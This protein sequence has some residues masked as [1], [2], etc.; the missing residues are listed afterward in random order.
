MCNISE[1]LLDA[2]K[3]GDVISVELPLNVLTLVCLDES[4]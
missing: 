3:L 2:N 1:I 4:R